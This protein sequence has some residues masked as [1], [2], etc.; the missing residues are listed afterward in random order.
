MRETQG[1]RVSATELLNKIVHL[2]A[3]AR[4]KDGG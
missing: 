1:E 3:E 2:S 4:L